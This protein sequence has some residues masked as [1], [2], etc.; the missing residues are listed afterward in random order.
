MIKCIN[1]FMAF[2]LIGLRV[3]SAEVIELDGK[4]CRQPEI[5]MK[6]SPFKVDVFCEDALGAYVGVVYRGT[7]KQPSDGGWSIESRY[8]QIGDWANGVRSIYRFDDGKHI[9]ISTS[10]VFGKSGIYL[11]DFAKKKWSKVF[12]IDDKKQHEF[13]IK[14]FDEKS[15]KL[16]LRDEINPAKDVDAVLKI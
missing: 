10:D 8:W 3:A 5:L 2:C 11:L 1:F 7:M 13:I 12:A 15:R 14:S 9:L 4:S 6:G 16:K